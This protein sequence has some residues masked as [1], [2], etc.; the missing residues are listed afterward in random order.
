MMTLITTVEIFFSKKGA[1]CQAWG[2]YGLDI[3]FGVLN[4]CGAKVH[5]ILP[6]RFSFYSKIPKSQLVT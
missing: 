5:A 6:K 2:G 4:T 3:P 1:E